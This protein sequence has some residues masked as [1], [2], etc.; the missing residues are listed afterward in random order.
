MPSQK[1]KYASIIDLPHPE[2]RTRARMKR[3]ERAGQF[4][5]F[6][7]LTGYSELVDEM[8]KALEAENMSIDEMEARFAAQ[9]EA[10]F[11]GEGEA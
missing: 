1:N 10:M 6:A 11:D 9:V 5:A 7:A 3:S 4:G 2:P 8:S